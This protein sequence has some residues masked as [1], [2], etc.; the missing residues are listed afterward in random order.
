MAGRFWAILEGAN[1]K[2]FALCQPVAGKWVVDVVVWSGRVRAW[3]EGL[4]WVGWVKVDVMSGQGYEQCQA[5]GVR[6]HH[7]QA[8]PYH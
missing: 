5:L 2:H 4:D 8:C 1:Q 3:C 6:G 7:Q